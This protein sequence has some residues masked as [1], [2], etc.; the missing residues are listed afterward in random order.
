M[1]RKSITATTRIVLMVKLTSVLVNRCRAIMDSTRHAIVR[2]SNGGG[3]GGDDVKA[4]IAGVEN[5]VVGDCV[6]TVDTEEN[7]TTT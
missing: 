1:Q 2:R 7:S 3:C 6:H 5:D 4:A